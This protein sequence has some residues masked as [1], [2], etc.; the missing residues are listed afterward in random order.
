MRIPRTTT[1]SSPGSPQLEEAG[2]QQ[3]RPDAAIKKERKKEIYKKKKKRR[4]GLS[5]CDNIYWDLPCIRHC[6][7]DLLFMTSLR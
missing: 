3:Q 5:L 6:L 7:A 2:T 4:L 1:K